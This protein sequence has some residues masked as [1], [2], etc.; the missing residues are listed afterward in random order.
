MNHELP[1]GWAEVTVNDVV[2]LNS[3]D[4]KV[5]DDTECAFVPMAL[6]PTLLTE[7]LSYE[8]KK[9]GACKA[10]YTQFRDGDLLLAKITPCFENGKS[11]ICNNLPN[12]IGAGSTEYFVF[13]SLGIETRFLH[14]FFK[15]KKFKD[16]CT[17]NMAGSV[18]HKRVPKDYLLEYR[19]PLPP[20]PEQI[21]IADKLDCV[22]ARV[23]TA[24]VR[25][26]KIPALIKRFRQSVLAAATS[27]E[28]TQEWREDKK[29]EWGPNVIA[30]QDIVSDEKYSLG[31]G[32]FGS[33]LKVSDYRE[34]G[35]PL[36]FVRDIRSE[37]FGKAGTK[38]VETNK[39]EELK[40]H[41]AEPG[42]ILITKMG[43]PPG[44]VAI[45][46][47]DRPTAVITSDCIKVR[48]NEKL[49]S[50]DFASIAFRSEPFQDQIKLI[51]A[52]V[53]QQKVNLKK[54]KTLEV[55][56][57]SIVEQHEIVRRVESLFALADNV[58]KQYQD[59][60]ARTDRLT[61]AILAKA[62]RG[63]LVPQNPDDEPSEVLLQRIQQQRAEQATAGKRGKARKVSG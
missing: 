60:K 35:H 63:E 23:N 47:L 33:N 2:L 17:V 12:G 3:K 10:G 38:Y 26:D 1:H 51:T 25:L 62:F 57:P 19:L 37:S 45:Y 58:E 6:M 40:A 11:A 39:F 46:P 42:D 22:L 24:Q 54:F 5:D 56:V 7:S 28:L 53:A 27:G 14:A 49:V 9:W 31:I 52:G 55:I 61:Q 59:A 21:R 16:D 13:K 41:Q 20:L 8:T 30:V 44:D 32:P 43:D 18:G 15:T 34:D 50:R 36:I 48:V 4:I 29:L